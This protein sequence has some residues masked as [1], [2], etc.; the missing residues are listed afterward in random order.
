MEFSPAETSHLDEIVFFVES[1]RLHQMALFLLEM[2]RPFSGSLG[3][4]AEGFAPL[5]AVF[6]GPRLSKHL[7]QLLADREQFAQLISRIEES[8]ERSFATKERCHG[9]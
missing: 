4:F 6:L 5:L 1:R 8:E 7:S 2:G 9:R 3:I